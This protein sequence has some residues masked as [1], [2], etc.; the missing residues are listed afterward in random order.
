MLQ[1]VLTM[2]KSTVILNNGFSCLVDITGGHMKS[3]YIS[4]VGLL[5]T[6]LCIGSIAIV[7]NTDTEDTMAETDGVRAG[8][9][10]LDTEVQNDSVRAGVFSA[11][12]DSLEEAEY[13]ASVSE[14]V[15]EITATALEEQEVFGFKNLGIAQVESGNLNVREA[16]TTDSKMVGKM[17]KNSACEILSTEG[18]WYYISSGE[19]TGYVKAE[20]IVTGDEAKAIAETLVRTVAISLTDSLNVRTE[21]NTECGI[22]T[23]VSTGEELE[24]VEVLD[25]WVKVAIDSDE[26]YVSADYV[27]IKDV[28]PRALTMTEAR[29]GV[30]VSDVRVDLVEY[31]C[32]FIGNPYVWGGTSLT[33]GA[34]C[35]G[36]VLSV[37]KNY[38]YTLPHYSVSQSQCG[39]KI[40]EDELLPGDLVFYSNGSR[41]NHVA[42]YIGGGQ[43]VHASSPKTGIRTSSYRY[44][45]PVKF[46][47][48]LED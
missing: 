8:V 39:T 31:A 33:K 12:S 40:S 30:G 45:T 28:L 17:P 27:E 41:I 11:L 36:F 3:R 29:Y 7:N 10:A 22:I 25:G 19:I 1:N 16:A 38:G 21:P 20:Y 13:T 26:G 34:D 47:R 2:L 48:I 14:T 6:T 9:C 5:V 44:R 23:T 18:E 46:V 37:F 35:S 4:A 42:I 24:F 15:N 43:V 32:Q